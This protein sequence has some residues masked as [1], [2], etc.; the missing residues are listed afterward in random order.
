MVDLFRSLCFSGVVLLLSTARGSAFC[1]VTSALRSS[2]SSLP[3]VT[4]AASSATLGSTHALQRLWD[5]LLRGAGLEDVEDR[6]MEV[7]AEL[8]PQ[9]T[10]WSKS[11]TP[12]RTV[13]A[14]VADSKSISVLVLPRES[15]LL[16]SFFSC[17]FPLKLQLTSYDA[18]FRRTP[19][20]V[21]HLFSLHSS[22]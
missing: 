9:A 7:E 18:A 17:V 21:A 12:M 4:A 14:E 16:G 10:A 13:V 2:R 22:S 8:F 15:L 5:E 20:R 3:A 6:V 11:F 1:P 19:F